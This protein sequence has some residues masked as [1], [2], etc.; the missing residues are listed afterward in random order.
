MKTGTLW[1]SFLSYQ[2]ALPCTLSSSNLSL[3]A[4]QE[5]SATTTW[6]TDQSN[7]IAVRLA[8]VTGAPPYDLLWEAS[9]DTQ[10]NPSSE[11]LRD[12]LSK[13]SVQDPLAKLATETGYSKTTIQSTLNSLIAVRNEC[14]HSGR[15]VANPTASD[16]I[17]YCDFLEKMAE[18]LVRVL[19]A[20]TF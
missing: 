12:S 5:R 6:I 4:K 20:H 18:G 3:R 15:A 11:V 9:A 17:G 16:V 8:S 1:F 7:G 14:A 13:F 19:T 10:G 2:I